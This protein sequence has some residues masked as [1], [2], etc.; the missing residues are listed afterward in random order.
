MWLVLF[1]N[2]LG[3]LSPWVGYDAGEHL[4]YINY[5]QTHHSLPLAS[6][7]WEMFQPPLYYLF[8]AAVLEAL[9]LKAAEP[10]ASTV[11]RVVG[12]GI[13]VVHI[14]IV[15]ATLR[16]LF[17]GER[18]KS[19]WG[20]L[21][22]AFLPPM[23]Y[24]SQ[25][26]TNETLAATL[27]SACFYLTLRLLKRERAQWKD[28]A[29]LGLCFGAALLTKSS[30]LLALPVVVGGIAWKAV[31]RP[32]GGP[33][34][35]QNEKDADKHDAK[36]AGIRWQWGLVL[37]LG[38][39]LAVCG[40]HY[41]RVW[42]RFGSPLVGN[43][44]PKIGYGWW[45]DDGYRTS[46][47]YLRFGGVLHHPWFAAYR[48]FADG[49]YST[50][51]GDGLFG[52]LGG[53]LDRPPWNHDL[54]AAGYW[55]ALPLMLTVLAGGFVAV[56]GF[57]RQPRA[58]WLMALAL[59][60][61][62]MLA[63]VQFA[64]A[65]PSNFNVKAF[66]GLSALIP[67]CAFG[68]LGLEA[69]AASWRPV[70]PV[71][72]IA[73]GLW[74]LNSYASFWIYPASP[75]AAIINAKSMVRE[76]RVSEAAPLLEEVLQR[77]PGNADVRSLQLWVLTTAGDFDRAG[78]QAEFAARNHPNHAGVQFA[79]ANL[80]AQRGQMAPAI[81][82]ARRAMELAPG[83][84]HFYEF[85]AMLLAKQGRYDEAAEVSR[86]GLRVDPASG[87]LRFAL[88]LGL[89]IHGA[90]NADAQLELAFRL[91]PHLPGAHA[92]LGA[93]LAAAG[94]LEQAASN[95]SEAIALHPDDFQ[96]H[97]QLAMV[98]GLQQKT[99]LAIEEYAETL[100]LKPDCVE[101][102]NNLAWIRAANIRAEFRNGAEAVQLAEHACQLTGYAQPTL[103]GT[104][105]AAYAETGRFD[106][107]VT[108]A[109]KARAL[110]MA[111]GQKD[112]AEKNQRLIEMFVAH[113]AY[114][115][116]TEPAKEDR[117]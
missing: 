79:L 61:L 45:Q 115:E 35:G 82:H 63:L 30:T 85:L 69:L 86:T 43:W 17:P 57:G 27:V 47:Y 23:I 60:F 39:C 92:M 40:W 75:S 96:L 34:S 18:A 78:T 65:I 2:N 36:S 117:P 67:F 110:A 31:E 77:E 103:M 29:A 55:L 1:A 26:V 56:L 106:E 107:A 76:G 3:R 64:L 7:G 4:D 28:Y 68:A 84:A 104:L 73:V 9:G 13:G 112:L 80:F 114:R 70:R 41:G 116:L 91:Q 52:G 20:L 12:F 8:G 101:A 74:A 53:G 83:D 113:Q 97:C 19:C 58:E 108:T 90:T 111:S 14:A 109:T 62:V 25:Y 98:F 11:L 87:Q 38:V 100:R 32:H 50:L 21:L 71:L 49:L 37:M 44:N 105:A 72:A 6:D 88:G 16:L 93:V 94:K 22:A 24:L 51:W 42:L 10:G 33:Q 102:L 48:S 54:M 89:L 5:I 99:A 95:F 46:S 66:Y 59:S 15:W 81:E